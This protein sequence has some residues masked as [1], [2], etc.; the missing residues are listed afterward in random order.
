MARWVE[1]ER[2]EGRVAVQETSEVGVRGIADECGV[3]M[4]V[5]VLCVCVRARACA[6]ARDELSS[7]TEQRTR[8]TTN[9][10]QRVTCR[11]LSLHRL[12]PTRSSQQAAHRV[13]HAGLAAGGGGGAGSSAA[14]VASAG[15]PPAGS[16][17]AE[18][19]LRV[20]PQG[21]TC[22]VQV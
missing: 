4:C 5:C 3:C 9:R 19:P 12:P 20:E 7:E 18:P 6:E 1:R 17:G 11:R 15:A 22:V 8:A 16:D 2:N 21:S 13:V 14:D 10:W